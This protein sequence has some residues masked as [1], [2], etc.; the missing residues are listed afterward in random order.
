MLHILS[1]FVPK[2]LQ[3]CIPDSVIADQ[4]DKIV[5][6][7]LKENLAKLPLGEEILITI[8]VPIAFPYN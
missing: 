7:Y 6:K 2:Y 4:N 8:T 1:P 3:V 5:T